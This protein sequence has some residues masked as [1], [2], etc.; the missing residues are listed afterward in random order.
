MRL[1]NLNY[2]KCNLLNASGISFYSITFESRLLY[3]N[4]VCYYVCRYVVL[5][6]Y[7]VLMRICT[8]RRSYVSV[9]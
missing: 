2:I 4:I 5:I 7:F 1:V 8:K 6:E 9:S 3:A